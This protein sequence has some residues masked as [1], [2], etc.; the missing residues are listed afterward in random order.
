MKNIQEKS[1]EYLLQTYVKYP[2]EITR[3]EGSFVWDGE[4]KKYLDFYS[5]HAVC[6]LGHCPKPIVDA[7]YQQ[8]QKLLFYSN[9][10]EMEPGVLLAEKLTTTLLPE[11]YQVYFANSG[12]EANETALK[13]ARKYTGKHHIISFA[14][15]FHGRGAYPLSVTGISSYHQFSPHFHDFTTFAELGNMES[16]EQCFSE[17]ETAAIICEPIQSMG[18][19]NMAEKE[20]YQALRTFCDEKNILLI[21]DEIQTGLGRTGSFWFSEYLEIYPDIITSAKG[22]ASGLPI[23]ATLIHENISKTIRKGEHATTFGGGPVVCAAANATVRT[24][25]REG[26]LESVQKSAEHLRS[27]L[28]KKY[29]VR[30]KG[31]LLGVET[32]LPGKE[33]VKRCLEKGLIIGTSHQGYVVRI[34]PPINTV[35]EEIDLFLH[36]FNNVQ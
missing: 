33:V 29:I 28:E 7:I 24:V 20:F 15:S 3:G 21:F 10:V 6:L 27:E 30:G 17:E 19:V 34:M 12:S 14:H 2:L 36:I 1:S 5:G 31:F 18:G 35:K 4:G 11:K 26:F 22:L 25:L 9:I 23:S 13:I 32:K 16:V 8:S